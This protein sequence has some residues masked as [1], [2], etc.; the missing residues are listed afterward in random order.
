M[1]SEVKKKT[2]DSKLLTDEYGNT[3]KASD[4]KDNGS[5]V[6]E[7]SKNNVGSSNNNINN[8]LKPKDVNLSD[9]TQKGGK[10]DNFAEGIKG[11]NYN[12][13]EK[14]FDE[15]LVGKLGYIKKPLAVGGE[16]KGYRYLLPN[17]KSIYLEKGWGNFKDPLHN[18]AYVRIPG[19]K[20][21]TLRV[22]LEGNPVLK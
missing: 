19:T 20:N 5:K 15:E 22:P 12:E 1:L 11:K 4:S 14:L 17:G 2:E 21:G 3:Y 10:I 7:S 18:G 9:F 13:L 16:D 6:L 8:T